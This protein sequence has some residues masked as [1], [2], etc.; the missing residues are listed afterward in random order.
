MGY[1]MRWEGEPS[2]EL[3]AA[4]QE[5]CEA[6]EAAVRARDEFPRGS[7]EAE[8][9]QPEVQRTY[10]VMQKTDVG[11]FRLNI[12]GMETARNELYKVGVITDEPTPEFPG[13]DAEWESLS[14]ERQDEIIN[15]W[16]SAVAPGD[17]HGIPSYKL[18]S[19]DGWLVTPA[20]IRTGLAWADYHEGEG[21]EYRLTDYVQEWVQWMKQAATM[22]G[23]RVW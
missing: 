3:V 23:F 8:S 19:N 12:W 15:E 4:H 16:Q 21:W 20:E 1:D 11:Y 10:D 6:F 13:H 22:G 17:T 7:L 2:P 14:E 18:G 9:L 5:A